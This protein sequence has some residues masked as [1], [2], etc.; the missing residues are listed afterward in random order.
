MDWAHRM[1]LA[2]GRAVLIRRA[3]AGDAQRIQRFTQNLSTQSRYERFF[4]PL[5]ELTREMLAGIVQRDATHGAALL[6]F[7]EPAH[8]D[9]VGMAQF[10]VVESGHAEVAV[11]VGESW[12]RIGLATQLL[13]DLEILAAAAGIGEAHADIL[14]GNEAALT[15]ARGV[16]CVVDTSVREPY[17]IHV[18]KPATAAARASLAS[19]VAK[20]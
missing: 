15:L 19:R 10:D 5:H 6:A 4:H 7:A 1:H 2:D 18:T 8:A 16:G 13:S 9:V 11:V 12:R 17:T 20:H 14:R 3:E